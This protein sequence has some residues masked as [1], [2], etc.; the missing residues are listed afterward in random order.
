MIVAKGNFGVGIAWKSDGS[1]YS[2]GHVKCAKFQ[3]FDGEGNCKF[4]G[5]PVVDRNGVACMYDYISKTLKYNAAATG[6]IT[7]GPRV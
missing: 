6:T 2:V 1:V 5:I 7:A 4:N 3:I